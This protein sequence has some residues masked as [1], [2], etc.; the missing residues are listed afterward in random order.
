M[1]IHQLDGLNSTQALLTRLRDHSDYRYHLHIATMEALPGY[2]CLSE[3]PWRFFDLI[4]RFCWWT[5]RIR[6]ADLIRRF[7]IL[8]ILVDGHEHVLLC[9]IL[10]S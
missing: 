9:G 3:A 6:R 5:L 1:R 10:F 2:W 4:P 7:S 8:L